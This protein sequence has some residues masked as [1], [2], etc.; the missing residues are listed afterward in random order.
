MS[1]L[2]YWARRPFA[3]GADMVHDLFNPGWYDRDPMLISAFNKSRHR[4]GVNNW[5]RENIV[6]SPVGQFLGEEG[7]MVG[8][9]LRSGGKAAGQLGRSAWDRGLSLGGSALRRTG[10][11][12]G[13]IFSGTRVRGAMN[14]ANEALHPAMFAF[15]VGSQLYG[16]D[17]KAADKIG[18][19]GFYRESGHDILNSASG[20]SG[21]PYHGP[22][23][24]RDWPGIAR[25]A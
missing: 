24:F 5:I 10:G 16:W 3:A 12:L 9:W 1:E 19:G 17:Q 14:F 4:Y 21:R 15:L 13:S 7:G 23:R 11:R 20:P 6:K 22:D 18:L 25:G 2:G 8:G